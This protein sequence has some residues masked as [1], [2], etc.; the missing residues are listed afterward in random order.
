MQESKHPI[1]VLHLEDSTPDA[2]RIRETLESA[3]LICEIVQVDGKDGFEWALANESFDLILTDF[4]IWDYDGKSAVKLAREKQPDA[5]VIV[6]SGKLGE[7]D[8]VMCLRLGATDYLLKERLDRLPSAVDRALDAAGQRKKARLADEGLRESEER[9]RQMA[10]NID[11]VFWMTNREL[12]QLLYVSPAYETI[13]GRTCASLYA[14]PIQWLEVIHPEDRERVQKAATNLVVTGSYEQ[15]FRIVRPDGS[16]RW[17]HDRAFPVKGKSGKVY[18][19]AGVARD[20]TERKKVEARLNENEDRFR[21]LA[22]NVNEVFWMTNLK[23]DQLL[24]ISPAYETIWG[25]TCASL[26]AS[27]SQ[28]LEAVHPEDRERVL[29]AAMNQAVTGTYE[30]DFRI[31]RPDGTIRWI[32]DRGFPVRNDAGEVYR[33]AGVATD[34]TERKQADAQ[35]MRVQRLESIG[36]LVGGIAH[37]LN[38]VLTPILIAVELLRQEFPDRASKHLADLRENAKRGADMVR[39]LSNFASGA[40]GERRLFQPVHLLQEIAKLIRSSVAKTVEV[41]L[42]HPKEAPTIAGDPTQLQQVLLNLCL[43]ARDAMP[44]GGKLELKLETFECDDRSARLLPEAKPGDYVVFKV[45][46]TG[47]GIAP[48]IIERIFDPFFTTKGRA[49]GSGLGL[50]TVVGVV[51]GHGGFVRVKSVM[52]QGSCFEIYLPARTAAGEPDR[53]RVAKYLF[54]GEG[55]LVLVVDDERVIRDMLKATLEKLDLKV[56]LAADGTEAMLQFAEHR[57][58]IALIITDLNMPQM[59]GLALAGVLRRMNPEGPIMV[60]TG[61]SDGDKVDALRKLG[62]S[63]VV[64]KP[65]PIAK[66][67]EAVEDSLS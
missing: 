31:V 10:E 33:L 8:A 22:E 15:D 40:D 16:I 67:I 64:S 12:D 37:D 3:G 20:I 5:P 27:P 42:L 28:W 34:I 55:R 49:K 44:G 23:Q 52:E 18:R 32:H 35:M 26:Y 6:I 65:F 58:Q 60:M 2:E 25:R 46:D 24:Y 50:S 30:Q 47:K 21:Q 62:I 36:A 14:S 56:V 19:I 39:Q 54:Q 13:W 9:F 29:Q 7:E 17:I 48:E 51:K 45:T 11:D 4:N 57:D 61:E 43:N 53:R 1:Q 59:D 41:V 63:N 38:N 66:L